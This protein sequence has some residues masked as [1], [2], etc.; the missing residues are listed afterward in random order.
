MTQNVSMHDDDDG[1]QNLAKIG[2][3]RHP[4]EQNQPAFKK[5]CIYLMT[6]PSLYVM[7]RWLSIHLHVGLQL[8]IKTSNSIS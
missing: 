4:A 7:F 5:I 2:Y 1:T 8:V 6:Y 3:F